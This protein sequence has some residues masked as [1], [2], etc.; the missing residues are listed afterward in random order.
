VREKKNL[1]SNA[2]IARHIKK[3]E[4]HRKGLA[5]HRDGLGRLFTE[6]EDLYSGVDIVLD[7]LERAIERLREI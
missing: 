5:K 6:I 1:L 3:L 4:Y 7:D 2:Q